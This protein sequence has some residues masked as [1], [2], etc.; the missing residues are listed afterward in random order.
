MNLTSVVSKPL[1]S[2]LLKVLMLVAI[3]GLCFS[4]CISVHLPSVYDISVFHKAAFA[5]CSFDLPQ[6]IAQLCVCRSFFTRGLICE[7]FGDKNI[8]ETLF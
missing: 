8:L 1:V 7:P 6:E 2:Y 5:V 4:A 3:C